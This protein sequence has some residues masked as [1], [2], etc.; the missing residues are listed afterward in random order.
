MG[1]K[2]A[3]SVD[4][5]KKATD[6]IEDASQFLT[7]FVIPKFIENNRKMEIPPPIDSKNLVS[8][9]HSSGIN[10]RYLGKIC[11]KIVNINELK[12]LRKL[13]IQEMLMRSAKQLLC[14]ILR[15]VKPVQNSE[16]SHWHLAPAISSF[17]SGML[18]PNCGGYDLTATHLKAAKGKVDRQDA[19][20]KKRLD[21]LKETEAILLQEQI[22]LDAA[23]YQQANEK[24][25]NGET[26]NKTKK[27]K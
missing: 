15:E 9:L 25:L 20:A 6:K 22:D 4:E 16:R 24:T 23:R 12:N 8:V 21:K 14:T 17:L 19:I 2:L 26:E 3:D 18:G 7:S 13:C 27:E 10:L 1:T 5:I 11:S